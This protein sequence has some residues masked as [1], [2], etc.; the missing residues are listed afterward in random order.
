MYVRRR[1]VIAPVDA[2]NA[3]LRWEYLRYVMD[4]TNIVGRY[5]RPARGFFPSLAQ[6]G[7]TKVFE[8][9]TSTLGVRDRSYTSSP[10]P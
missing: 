7:S 2:R 10:K 6:N 5:V 8:S 9:R 4:V 3:R 1:H